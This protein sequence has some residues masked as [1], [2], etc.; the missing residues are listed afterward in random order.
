MFQK[1]KII[2]IG[3]AAFAILWLILYSTMVS[4]NWSDR[5]GEVDD[6]QENLDRWVKLYKPAKDGSTLALP[7]G[8]RALEEEEQLLNA[9]RKKLRGI[10]FSPSR[11]M[12]KYTLA[13]AGSNDPNN[14]FA[15]KRTELIANVQKNL[16]FKLEP[17]LGADLT[18][19]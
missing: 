4:P 14:Y 8:N 1:N 17:G 19:V 6:A 11:S 18:I 13:G 5:D 2:F 7:E 16:K 3:A 12:S 10:E 9:S 15:K